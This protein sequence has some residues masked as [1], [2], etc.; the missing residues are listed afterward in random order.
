[1][2]IIGPNIQKIRESQ[3][4]TQND[5]V[6][7]CNLLEWDISRGT[8]AKI[9]ARVRRVTDQ[10]VLLLARALRVPVE[11]LFKGSAPL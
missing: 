6:A 10:E 11:V 2:N 7:R 5:L 3:G 9:E 8:L 1:M 4:L